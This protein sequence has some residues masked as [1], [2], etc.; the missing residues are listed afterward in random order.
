MEIDVHAVN[1]ATNIRRDDGG[2]QGN[3]RITPSAWNVVVSQ[4]AVQLLSAVAG[5]LLGLLGLLRGDGNPLQ[6]LLRK[7][8]ME[9]N[10]DDDAPM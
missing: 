5:S 2:I 3:Y 4:P 10:G 8:A 1:S 6:P 7:R 9:Q